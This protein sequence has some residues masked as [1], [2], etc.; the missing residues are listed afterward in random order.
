MFITVPHCPLTT[1]RMG[2]PRIDMSTRSDLRPSPGKRCETSV[3]LSF[4]FRSGRATV[5]T[6]VAAPW[7]CRLICR[8]E[9]TL[10]AGPTLTLSA[11]S[12]RSRLRA[13]A[14]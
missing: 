5:Q 8:R 12:C 4:N 3:S 2:T 14:R 10:T 7:S 9:G 6:G 11:R 13:E 1:R